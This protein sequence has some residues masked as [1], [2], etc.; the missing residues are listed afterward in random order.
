M[1]MHMVDPARLPNLPAIIAP[2]RLGTYLR[3]CRGD[4]QR[5]VR[6]Y[7]WNVEIAAAMWGP[8]HV[9]EVALRNA[10]HHRLAEYAGRR[11]WWRRLLLHHPQPEQVAAAIRAAAANHPAVAL[12]DGHV[13]AE[14][15]LG[16]WTA[17]LANRY[18]ARLWEPALSGVFRHRPSGTR[19]VTS[20]PC[21]TRCV[22]CGTALPTMS[23]S[24]PGHWPT[25]MPPS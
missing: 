3:A 14:L 12:T 6:L 1:T 16:F 18:H 2:E 10:I 21:S 11:D 15:S 7:T 9:L 5:A 17:L 19:R 25:I 20:R 24:S 8:L 4:P 22:G 13:V 23:R